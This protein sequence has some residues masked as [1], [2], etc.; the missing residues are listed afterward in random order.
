MKKTFLKLLFLV[1]AIVVLSL[2]ISLT[3]LADSSGTCGDNL[4][5]VLDDNGTLTISGSGTMFDYGYSSNYA[6]W[7]A[8][9]AL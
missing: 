7:S 8:S 5:W 6:P 9:L 4:T 2:V 1:C 3:A